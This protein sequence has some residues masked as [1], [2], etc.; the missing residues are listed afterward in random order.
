MT[1]MYTNVPLLDARAKRKQALQERQASRQ[2]GAAT[3]NFDEVVQVFVGNVVTCHDGVR[4][5][6]A[7]ICP[8]QV[9]AID[10]RGYIVYTAAQSDPTSQKLI[11]LAHAEVIEIPKDA[12]L[13]PGFVDTH[14]HAPQYLNAGT[15]LDRPL[16]QWLVE[17][18]YK[19]E[20]RIDA[21]PTGLG[22]RVYSKLVSRMIEQGTTLASVFGTLTPEANWELAKQFHDQGVRAHVGKIMMDRYGV[23]GYVEARETSFQE[24]SRFIEDWS[25]RF[26]TGDQD[27]LVEPVLTPRFEPTCSS[28]LLSEVEKMSTETGIRV[29]S[30]M[31]ESAGQVA[32][33]KQLLGGKTDVEEFNERKLLREG[34]LMAHCTHA[35]S[36]DLDLLAKTGAS[37][38]HCPLSNVYFSAEKQLPLRE[39]LQRG[40]AVGLGSDISGGYA[41]GID[42]SCR[43]AVGVSRL[44][45]GQKRQSDDE[46]TLAITWDESLYLAT[47]GGA[48]AMTMDHVTGSLE[49]GKSF[50]AQLI[51]LGRPASRI[52]VFDEN[53][54]LEE[55]VEKWWC[56]GT[57]ANRAGVWVKGRRIL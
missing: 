49:V 10:R 8:D 39:A 18:T 14:I 56:N 3:V 43:W 9:L 37:I 24:T 30:H 20:A 45:E 26:E 38:S 22:R 27:L 2:T 1:P 31:C 12:W 54:K 50:D 28:E 41:L 48:R 55:L 52:D 57:E 6:R 15:A 46:T 51:Q 34:C 23:D 5:Q 33:S 16:E 19:A 35:T 7:I 21:D 13:L 44:R 4:E 17:Y 25:S 40:V 29:Q 32:W 36:A 42:N 11:Q 53:V 47:L